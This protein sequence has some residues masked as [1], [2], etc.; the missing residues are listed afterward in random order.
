MTRAQMIPSDWIRDFFCIN[1]DIGV[2]Y[3]TPGGW[4][5]GAPAWISDWSVGTMPP[6]EGMARYISS[7]MPYKGEWYPSV[8][9]SASAI[10]RNYWQNVGRFEM[11]EW[12]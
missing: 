10:R 1:G 7:T 9:S 12:Q 8:T 6:H 5:A 2:C 3:I 11:G 4:V